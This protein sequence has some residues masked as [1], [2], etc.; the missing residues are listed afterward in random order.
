MIPVS[1]AQKAERAVSRSTWMLEVAPRVPELPALIQK[2]D[3]PFLP[4]CRAVIQAT[5]DSV[6]GY[7]F[8]LAAFLALGAAGAVALE[9][10]VAI[11]ATTPDVLS[12][13]HGPFVRPEYAVFAGDLALR[14]DAA[15]V[16]TADVAVAFRAEGVAGLVYRQGE[17]DGGDYLDL[18][19]GQMRL[20][21]I[22]FH[23]ARQSFLD[24]FKREDFREAL[25]A[26][27]STELAAR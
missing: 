18:V 14:A 25:H 5:S 20:A 13:V 8:D 9:R 4:Y 3:D 11:V 23:V 7:I 17:F 16:T 15:S 26:A 1:L 22:E 10:A 27:A 2:Y 6:A 12:V 19:A 21:G 24:G